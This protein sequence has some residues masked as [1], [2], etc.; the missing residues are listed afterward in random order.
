MNTLGSPQAAVSFA[1]ALDERYAALEENPLMY[2]RS[3]NR[4]HSQENC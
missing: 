4:L 3:R 2:E 1:D